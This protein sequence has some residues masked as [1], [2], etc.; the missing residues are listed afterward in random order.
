MKKIFTRVLSLCL[1]V[2]VLFSVFAITASAATMYVSGAETGR[3]YLRKSPGSSSYYLLL[4]NG[5]AV[6][7]LG[8]AW[9]KDSVLYN[10]VVAKGYTGWIT[11][12]YLSYNSPYS[13]Y[14]RARVYNVDWA[15]YH[16]TSAWG[17][18]SS[19]YAYL[20]DTVYVDWSNV[21]NGRVYGYRSNGVYGWFTAQYLYSY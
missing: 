17:T 9:G 14:T 11:S 5:T 3:V 12:R 2:M 4:N 21:V 10:K 15:V 19:G 1:A 7:S 18:G 16:W 13:R 20:G 8:T 6:N